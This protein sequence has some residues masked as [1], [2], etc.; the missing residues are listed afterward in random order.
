LAVAVAG[1]LAARHLA[2][3]PV[4]LEY[5]GEA[6]HVEGVPLAEML[7]LRQ[8]VPIYA[9]P[10]PDRFNAALYGPLYYLLGARLVDENKPA[11][12]PLRVISLLALF[13]CAAGCAVMAFWMGRS[14][15]A[16]ALAPLVFLAYDFVTLYGTSFRCDLIAL[17]FFFAGFLIAYRFQ[18]ERLILLSVPLM[19]LGFFFKQQFVAG[20]LA[21]LLFLVLK[22]RY[23]WALEFAGLSAL[24]GLGLFGLFQF[25]VFRGQ[26]FVQ[27]CLFFNLLSPSQG[28]FADG[29]L[30]FALVLLWPAL[31]A[32]HFLRAHPNPLLGCYLGCAVL[33][34][35][36]TVT[37]PGSDIN[38][39]LE[40][41]LILSFVLAAQFAKNI[42]APRAAGWLLAL[43]LALGLGQWRTCSA[44]AAADFA[45][46][47]T[48]Q[49]FL[50]RNA[51]PGARA[52]GYYTGD[53]LRAGLETP[54][55][56]LY[57]YTTLVRKGA[58]P[59]RD[60]LA[61][62]RDRRFGVITLNF[63]LEGEKDP[64]RKDFYL[65]ERLRRAILVN[66][67]LA[68]SLEMPGPEKFDAADRLY[69][70]A[71]RP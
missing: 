51:S 67:R 66:Y 12:L 15:F 14:F 52:L 42:A 20:P 28:F 36:A 21:V 1:L 18:N 53:L 17:F 60:L 26:A 33:L 4:R 22:K 49:D 63:D 29:L 48:Q 37:R 35:L 40:C 9:P 55:S 43:A 6:S 39:F 65:T 44:P 69:V 70:W 45:L 68:A 16:A 24:M 31:M 25:V 41:V 38:Y 50:R 13:G 10:S 64:E 32:L 11:Y 71:P 19:V 8:G 3:W 59:E 56:D 61:Q 30:F 47:R 5:P 58:L 23:R 27:H 7:H 62:L 57:E 46:D 34:G 54:I 2:T